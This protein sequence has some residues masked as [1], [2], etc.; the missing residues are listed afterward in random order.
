MSDQL[1]TIAATSG[2]VLLA[3]AYWLH[4][5][6]KHL[7]TSLA[8]LGGLGALFIP[9]PS[10]FLASE[11]AAEE[12]PAEPTHY[13]VDLIYKLQAQDILTRLTSADMAKG[14]LRLSR[15]EAT[16]Y[17]QYGED[18]II[19]EIFR[20]IGTTNRYFVDFGS[21][22]G[23]ENNTVL[24]LL[25]GWSGLW[26]D[27]HESLIDTAAELYPKEVESGRLKA[28]SA[29][30]NAENIEELFRSSDVP[31]S[32]DLLSVD[33][34]RN[35]YWVWKNIQSYQPRVV[36]MEYNAVFPPGMKWVVDYDAEAFW[37]GTS[38]FGA[39]LTAYEELGREKG[40]SLVGCNLMGSNAFFVRSDLA[41]GKFDAP[42][43]AE[44]HYQPARY[45]LMWMKPGHTRRVGPAGKLELP[46]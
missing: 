35:D 40:Y 30:V 2:V 27:A 11:P 8:L 32:F 22:E 24:L 46:R 36:V 13:Q 43:T 17:S 42:F 25:A 5:R 19:A 44:N 23:R 26:M 9:L 31:E 4:T 7:P 1:Y 45:E 16:I 21:S 34:D 20:R 3:A 39:S 18:G 28:R 33:I 29:F 37:D 10:L 14:P 15:H 38:H 6:N 12:T 41:E